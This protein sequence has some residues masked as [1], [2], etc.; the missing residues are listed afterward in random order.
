LILLGFLY[1]PLGEFA[2]ELDRGI[3]ADSMKQRHVRREL[4]ANGIAADQHNLLAR[5]DARLLERGID[6]RDHVIKRVGISCQVGK[7]T[8]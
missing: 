7:N 8:P 5:L 4:R 6:V 1:I 2:D 3:A